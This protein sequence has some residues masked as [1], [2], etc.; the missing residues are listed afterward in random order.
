MLRTVAVP[1]QTGISLRLK[2]RHDLRST[3][4]ADHRR[5]AYFQ[6]LRKWRSGEMIPDR[7]SS[8]C[9]LLVSAGGCLGLA[10]VVQYQAGPADFA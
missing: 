10:A 3:L 7:G 9:L 1:M 2:A 6:R 5:L 8:A 4:P